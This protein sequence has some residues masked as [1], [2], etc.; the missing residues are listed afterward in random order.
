MLKSILLNA[1]SGTATPNNSP[2]VL[3]YCTYAIIVVACVWLSFASYYYY[4]DQIIESKGALLSSGISFIIAA[5]VRSV[6]LYFK[7]TGTDNNVVNKL[8]R[9]N[10]STLIPMVRKANE[11]VSNK[12][13]IKTVT[14]IVS[15]YTVYKFIRIFI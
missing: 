3:R 5:I 15:I 1:I 6:E 8:I 9:E 11:I 10:Y 13:F 7:P 2:P 14:T 12:N 4:T